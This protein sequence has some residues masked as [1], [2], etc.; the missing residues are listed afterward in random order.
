MVITA[1]AHVTRGPGSLRALA[2]EAPPLFPLLA[3]WRQS[4]RATRFFRMFV[5]GYRRAI[6]DTNPQQDL[7]D[8]NRDSRER[9]NTVLGYW[10]RI[11]MK[12]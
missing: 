11:V 10:R 5:F 6:H 8:S 12:T 9:S 3:A 2:P 1:L 7:I 4:L